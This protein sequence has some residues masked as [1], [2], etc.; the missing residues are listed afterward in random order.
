M[1]RIQLYIFRQLFWW[2]VLVASGLT[3]VVW[4]MQSLRFVEMIVNR[5]LSATSFLTFTVLLLPTLIS[6][7]GPIAL[8]AA[9]VFTYNKMIS[10]SEIVVMRASGMSPA[11]AIN[12]LDLPQ[13]LAPTM[14]TKAPF[15]ME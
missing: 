7:L 2:T 10:D 13:P 4:L 9:A 6:L 14:V 11:S 3:C 12:R 15:S 5:G 1:G 8:F